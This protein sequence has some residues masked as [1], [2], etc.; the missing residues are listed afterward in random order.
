MVPVSN[1]S[2]LW[3]RLA[4]GELLCFVCR[5]G[6]LVSVGVAC[7]TAVENRGKQIVWRHSISLIIEGGDIRCI[8]V[9]DA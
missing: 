1:G 5:R 4:D 9:E 7:V 8:N 6:D 2:F 3:K